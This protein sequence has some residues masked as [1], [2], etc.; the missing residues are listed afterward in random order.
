[1]VP[2]GHLGWGYRDRAEFLA[3]A[4]EYIADGLEHNQLIA[5][6]GDSTPDELHA[7]LAGMPA[8]GERLGDIR[9]IPTK[10]HYVY[11]PG[12]DVVDAKRCLERY[13]WNAKQATA[14]GY[15]GLRAVSDVTPVA[16]TAEQRAALTGLEYLVD[17]KMA[18]EPFSALCA[19][20][21]SQLGLAAAELTC[22]HPFV[23]KDAATFRLYAES[24]ADF[25]LAG[26][27]DAGSHDIFTTVLRRTWPLTGADTLVIDAKDLEFIG[28]RQLCTLDQWAR[29]DGR[30]VLLRT[31][32]RM[33]TRLVGL[34][35]LTNVRVESPFSSTA[36]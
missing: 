10:D 29:A 17:Q 12:G 19:Y 25:A 23:G 6:V 31:G 2:F 34:L 30:K 18:V 22:L 14:N 32:Q 26:D 9:V 5:Y 7:E 24:D 16:R 21:T 11:R 27:I 36:I 20:D 35:D 33:P 3:R 8:I 1:L 4:A 28:H 15:T 13:V